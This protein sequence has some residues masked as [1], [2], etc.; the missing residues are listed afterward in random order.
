MKTEKELRDRLTA[1]SVEDASFAAR[2]LFRAAKNEAEL[3]TMTNR[4]VGGE[5][6]QY[7]LGEWEFYGLPFEVGEGVLIPR[8]DTEVLVEEALDFIG[9]RKVTVLDLCAG[10]GA[11]G[12]A[13]AVKSDAAVTAVEKSEEAFD[14]LL[15]NIRR[16]GVSV[17]AVKG[18][19][20]DDLS[21]GTFDVLVSN[22]PYIA[23]AVVP[24][25][26]T[27]RREPTVALDG[28]EDGLVFYRRI[29]TAYRPLVKPGGLIAAE[30]GYDQENEVTALFAEAGLQNIR[31][32]RD[33]GGN[34]RVI[35]GTVPIDPS[36]NLSLNHA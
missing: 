21:L 17:K 9:R 14:Y 23:S 15:R 29:L 22:P 30:I 12:I 7:I 24:T 31:T 4:L 26:E 1:A 3:E 32:R 34:P 13:I 35:L 8:A 10:S 33:Y 2:Q 20:F 36:C 19:I 11:V 25:L 27:V 5:P 28:G 16:N 6:L 18:D